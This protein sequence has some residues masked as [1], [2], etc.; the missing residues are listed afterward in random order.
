MN[1]LSSDFTQFCGVIESRNEAASDGDKLNSETWH[2]WRKQRNTNNAGSG[3]G[4]NPPQQSDDITN[5]SDN[6]K[7]TLEWRR[8]NKHKTPQDYQHTTP[9]PVKYHLDYTLNRFTRYVVVQLKS[10]V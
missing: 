10:S 2:R 1:G 6:L 9:T 5:N 8:L 4:D 7:A 3:L